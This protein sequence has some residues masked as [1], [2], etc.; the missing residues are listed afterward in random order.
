MGSRIA[1]VTDGEADPQHVLGPSSDQATIFLPVVGL[2][3]VT[4][5]I[6][7][8]AAHGARVAIAPF[9]VGARSEQEIADAA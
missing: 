3:A 9:F 4:D 6:S 5:R 1:R 8:P 2:C 7:T